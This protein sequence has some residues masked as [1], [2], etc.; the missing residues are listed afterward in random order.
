MAEVLE[1][2]GAAPVKTWK[3]CLLACFFAQRRGNANPFL[4]DW[5]RKDSVPPTP[6][7]ND[8]HSAWEQ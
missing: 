7:A 3:V 6:V 8:E 2:P 5:C 4:A 1:L